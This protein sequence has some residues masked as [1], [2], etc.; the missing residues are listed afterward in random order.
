MCAGQVQVYL[1]QNWSLL[2][3]AHDSCL[4]AL[5]KFP[6]QNFGLEVEVLY[7]L[8]SWAADGKPVLL[9]YN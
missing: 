8:L 9:C 6:W 5:D 2:Q 3:R 7:C 1:F 4:K